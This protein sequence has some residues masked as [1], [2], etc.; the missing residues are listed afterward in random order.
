ME[1]ARPSLQ[2]LIRGLRERLAQP[3]PGASAQWEMAPPYRRASLEHLNEELARARAA[4]VLILLYPNGLD[5]AFPLTLRTFHVAYHKGQVS[6]PGGACEP[7]E[8]PV[9]AAL[10]ETEEELGPLEDPV[11]FLGLLTPLFVPPSGFMVHPVVGYLPRRPTF[12]PAPIEVAEVL[13]ATLSW[14][15]DPRYQGE[16]E[17][18][19]QGVRWR[20]PV[21]RLGKH[22]IWGATAMIL[23]EFRAVVR[24]ALASTR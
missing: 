4:A 20:I 12:R 13:E 2:A 1:R 15:L 18:E 17:R 23:A 19:V 7:G 6:L 16:E 3:L 21:F 10:R 9:E 24:E 5:L 22:T 8:S 14:L 11:E